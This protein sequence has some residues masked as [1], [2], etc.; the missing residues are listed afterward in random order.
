MPFSTQAKL[1][2]TSYLYL[3]LLLSLAINIEAKANLEAFF[4]GGPQGLGVRRYWPYRSDQ[5]GCKDHVADLE[6]SYKEASELIDAAFDA[7]AS[8][9][10]ARPGI[11]SVSQRRDWNRKAQTMASMFGV[12]IDKKG[13]P[14]AEKES[15]D[16]FQ[17]VEGIF[18]QMKEGMDDDQPKGA[19]ISGTPYRTPRDAGLYCGVDGWRYYGP[20]DNDPAR[21]GQLISDHKNPS[22]PDGAWYFYHNYMLLEGMTPTKHGLCGPNMYAFAIAHLNLITFCDFAWSSLAKK[23]DPKEV[24]HTDILDQ[25]SRNSLSSVWV[26]ELAH[27][28]GTYKASIEDALTDHEAVDGDGKVQIGPDGLSKKTYGVAYVMNLAKKSTRLATHTADA[29][30]MFAVAMYLPKWNW[31]K[32]FAD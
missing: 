29:Y 25:Q 1:V 31:S 13:G 19:A 16:G 21:P 17:Y 32:G 26:H 3:F 8:L 24:K 20:N 12:K 14:V 2:R 4:T 30:S 22:Y 7:I 27:F 28:Y 5:N 6:S 18:N 9:K 23:I 15:V 10:E 11:L